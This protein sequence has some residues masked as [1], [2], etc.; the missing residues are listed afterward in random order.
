M[1]PHLVQNAPI[2]RTSQTDRIIYTGI[3]RAAPCIRKRNIHNQG[4]LVHDHMEMEEWYGKHLVTVHWK[5]QNQ[6]DNHGISKT[7]AA[8]KKIGSHCVQ[9]TRCQDSSIRPMGHGTRTPYKTNRRLD[10]KHQPIQDTCTHR[11]DTV[12]WHRY[13]IDR[14]YTPHNRLHRR[15]MERPL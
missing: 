11:V 5:T 8:K 6:D 14:I 12:Q 15:R 7:R 13:E 9:N 4:L 3:R 10:A 2:Q 1:P